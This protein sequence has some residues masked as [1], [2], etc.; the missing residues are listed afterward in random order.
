MLNVNFGRVQMMVTPLYLL[1]GSLLMELKYNFETKR[2]ICEY[3]NIGN[4]K[5]KDN[6]EKSQQSEK[7]GD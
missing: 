6:T 2:A 3:V 1:V 7:Q 5:I 4:L